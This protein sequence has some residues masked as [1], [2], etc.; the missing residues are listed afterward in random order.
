MAILR[1]GRAVNRA[2]RMILERLAPS[3]VSK[4]SRIAEFVAAIEPLFDERYY[5]SRYP[6]VR[7]RDISPAEHYIREGW[8]QGFDPAPWFSTDGY[9]AINA[10]TAVGDLPPF[11]H[12][13]LYGRA[14]GRTI[15]QTTDARRVD[16]PAE[17]AL[18][19]PQD[20]DLRA[21]RAR[22]AHRR[23]PRRLSDHIDQRLDRL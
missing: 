1:P 16:G 11:V 23:W 14:E 12:Y 15:A 4:P 3:Y 7:E 10:D 2:T 18:S 8:Q 20:S 17:I 5:L 6:H 21:L 22:D 19:A 9:I 13:V